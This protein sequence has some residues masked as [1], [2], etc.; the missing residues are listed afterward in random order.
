MTRTVRRAFTLI[1]LLVVI[2]IIVILMALLTPALDQAVYQAE[3]AVCAAKQDALAAATFSYTMNHKRFY[4]YRTLARQ[5][6]RVQPHKVHR[7]TNVSDMKVLQSFLSLNDNLQDPLVKPVDLTMITGNLN[8]VLSGQVPQGTW[9]YS[10]YAYWAGWRYNTPAGL[11]GMHKLG[12]GF[13]WGDRT[14]RMI[15]SDHDMVTIAQTNV[16][17]TH[18]DADGVMFNQVLQ[19]ETAFD[20]Y[21]AVRLT[22]STWTA[23]LGIWKRGAIDMNAV[24]DDGSVSRYN[25]VP[26]DA[27]DHELMTRIPEY[28]DA[29]GWNAGAGYGDSVPKPTQ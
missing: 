8:D 29:L 16:Q 12:D 13:E 17:S 22:Y 27:R 28:N 6:N 24:F 23:A 9:I 14:F 10:S 20:Y 25:S 4:P 3:L 15:A 26:A 19:N 21:S 7:D 5:F 18:P 2:T 11:K 1:E